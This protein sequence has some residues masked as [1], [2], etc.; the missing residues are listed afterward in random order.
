MPESEVEQQTLPARIATIAEKAKVN[1]PIIM[2]K[3]TAAE[4][5]MR[6][7]YDSIIDKVNSYDGTDSN[8]IDE[9][10]EGITGLLVKI[11]ESYDVNSERRKEIT[12]PFDDFKKEIMEYEKKVQYDGKVDNYYTKLRKALTSIEQKRQDFRNAKAEEAKKQK[13][14]EDYKIDIITKIKTNLSNLVI[15]RVRQVENGSRDFFDAKNTNVTNFDERAKLFQGLQAKLKIEHY[16][17][18]FS[19]TTDNTRITADELKGLITDLKSQESYDKWNK[20]TNEKVIPVL[21]EWKAKIPQI[22]EEMLSIAKADEETQARLLKEKE[23]REKEEKDRKDKE[24][25]DLQAAQQKSIESDADMSKM[26]NEF[27]AQA[28]TQELGDEGAKVRVMKFTDKKL[29]AKALAQMMYHVLINPDFPGIQKIDSKTKTLQVD[30]KGRPVYI[31]AAQSWIDLFLKLKCDVAIE[32]TKIFED[33]K[34]T[35]RK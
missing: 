18:C 26:N 5:A 20:L 1:L 7:R 8:E 27:V 16:D 9:I 21:N 30:D 24:L 29:I 11:K 35:V 33:A 22:K 14:R 3:T 19:I 2:E 34:V 32:G 13:E 25:T 12:T 17:F 28:Q 10:A 15:D 6:N 4:V 31:D 23:D